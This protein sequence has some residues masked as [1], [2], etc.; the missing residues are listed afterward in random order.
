MKEEKWSG[1]TEE[2]RTRPTDRLPHDQE[3][4]RVAVHVVSLLSHLIHRVAGREPTKEVTGHTR[5]EVTSGECG[6]A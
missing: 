3:S 2:P 5:S 6:P 4:N 1:V